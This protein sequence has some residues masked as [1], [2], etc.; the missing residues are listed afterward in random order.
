MSDDFHMS[1]Q[2]RRWLDLDDGPLLEAQ[3]NQQ[4]LRVQ[5]DHL[6]V[7]IRKAATSASSRLST[8]EDC[9]GG[10]HATR[11]QMCLARD[12]GMSRMASASRE[13]LCT[14]VH[15]PFS[16]LEKAEIQF[17]SAGPR[18]GVGAGEAT[19]GRA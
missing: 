14:I 17:V 9:G 18:T 16:R 13:K 2:P 15:D 1:V 6:R 8:G 10:V 3:A 19:D 7:A 12:I 4:R 11:P 5:R